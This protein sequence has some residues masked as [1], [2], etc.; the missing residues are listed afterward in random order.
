MGLFCSRAPPPTPSEAS[1]ALQEVS[2]RYQKRLRYLE[3]NYNELRE[4]ARLSLRDGYRLVAMGLLQQRQL[5][6]KQIDTIQKYDSLV[7]SLRGEIEMMILTADTVGAIRT[8]AQVLGELRNK[9]TP[10]EVEKLLDDVYD[11][12]EESRQA[13]DIISDRGRELETLQLGGGEIDE[14]ELERELDTLTRENLTLPSTPQLSRRPS[15]NYEDDE[16]DESSI[17]SPLR[18]A[19]DD[20]DM[21][22]L[23]LSMTSNNTSS[24]MGTIAS[25]P[26]TNT[27]SSLSAANTTPK[28]SAPPSMKKKI[29]IL[30]K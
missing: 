2:D 20:R 4:R 27:F 21:E 18:G 23:S 11:H 17:N 14:A 19:S 3:K 8:S 12:V 7:N 13:L 24:R 5:K 15:S 30:A 26:S 9:V 1:R 28:S 6:K 22:M 25:L 16:E 10:D 29:G